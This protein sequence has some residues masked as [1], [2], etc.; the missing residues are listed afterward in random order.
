M[1]YLSV[2]H[3]QISEH[4]LRASLPAGRSRKLEGL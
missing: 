2:G 3:T 1:K 4:E